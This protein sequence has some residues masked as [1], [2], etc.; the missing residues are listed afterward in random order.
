MYHA[1]L[2]TIY[3]V[4]GSLR[5][6]TPWILDYSIAHL[7]APPSL[8]ATIPCLRSSCSIQNGGAGWVWSAHFTSRPSGLVDR[9]AWRLQVSWAHN[10]W[11]WVCLRSRDWPY[12]PNRAFGLPKLLFI[13]NTCAVL[14]DYSSSL[15]QR[16]QN[17]RISTRLWNYA[18]GLW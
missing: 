6:K 9:V 14:R 8:T 15:L 1:L 3:A 5:V 4:I 2:P 17:A 12:S 13:S 18:Y 16:V 7:S 11:Y 10:F